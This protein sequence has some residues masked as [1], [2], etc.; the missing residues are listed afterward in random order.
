MFGPPLNLSREITYSEIFCDVIQQNL[1]ALFTYFKNTKK[2]KRKENLLVLIKVC[3]ILRTCLQSQ[4]T[5]KYELEFSHF[6]I[7]L[8]ELEGM[9]GRAKQIFLM[10]L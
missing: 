5:V 6:G 9:L 7:A 10:I 2:W 4:G 8:L 3:A 1:F